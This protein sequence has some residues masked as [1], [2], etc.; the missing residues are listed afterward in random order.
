MQKVIISVN[1]AVVIYVN[2]IT[3]KARKWAYAADWGPHALWA[4]LAHIF[5]RVIERFG[6]TY[7]WL[8]SRMH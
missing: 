3:W 1:F 5:A 2:P 6:R 4:L 8:R 7:D